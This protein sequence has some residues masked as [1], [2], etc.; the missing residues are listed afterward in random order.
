MRTRMLRCVHKSRGTRSGFSHSTLVMAMESVKVTRRVAWI[1]RC[2]KVARL[3]K[4]VNTPVSWYIHV[5]PPN[6]FNDHYRI[7][8]T[9]PAHRF[10]QTGRCEKANCGPWIYLNFFA[11][12]RR[13]RE[14]IVPTGSRHLSANNVASFITT[15]FGPRRFPPL[16]PQ[17]KR[18]NTDRIQ[19]NRGLAGDLAHGNPR[20]GDLHGIDSNILHVR[21]IERRKP[22]R[23]PLSC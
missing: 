13:T 16:E 3:L 11:G 21:H 19:S 14:T 18:R 8:N 22:N 6:R 4:I 23:P 17:D 1:N 5:C 10:H 9:V 20:R 7:N 15:L 2:S 12:H